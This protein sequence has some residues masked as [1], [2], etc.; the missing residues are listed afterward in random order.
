MTA[1]WPAGAAYLDGEDPRH[2][3]GLPPLGRDL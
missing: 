2:R 1:P 3:L